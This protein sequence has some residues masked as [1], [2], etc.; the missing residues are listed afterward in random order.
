MPVEPMPHQAGLRLC[1]VGNRVGVGQG[2]C[3]QKQARK[4]S[5]GAENC[6]GGVRGRWWHQ[7]HQRIPCHP[8]AAHEKPHTENKSRVGRKV[9]PSTS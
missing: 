5:R 8:P 7:W 4:L 6:R 3:R 2:D 1:I 9:A